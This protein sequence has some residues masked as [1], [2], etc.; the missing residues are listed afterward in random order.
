MISTHNFFQ[1]LQ[2][3]FPIGR[4]L[5]FSTGYAGLVVGTNFV[6]NIWHLELWQTLVNFLSIAGI[7]ICFL[8]RQR[9]ID[10]LRDF[11]HDAQYFPNRPLHRGLIT[12]QQLIALGIS[13]L[14]IEL[15][16]VLVI[17]SIL[18]YLIVLTFTFLMAKDF[19]IKQWLEKHFT[20]HFLIHEVFFIIFGWFFIS[21]LSSDDIT[22]T[23]Q[24]FIYTALLTG[25]I[26]IELIRKFKPRLDPKGVA[27]KDSYCVMWGRTKT[28]ILLAC[29]MML[30][31]IS[32]SMIKS[33][34]LF[35]LVGVLLS[36]VLW[37]ARK[38]DKRVVLVGIVQYMLFAILANIIW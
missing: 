38:R 18:Q 5:L 24:L 22:Q 14:I 35:I 28:I 7:F 12:K 17:G 31:S 4:V 9:A 19:F 25:P 27:V 15:F 37:K 1:Y 20:T 30:T 13:A 3:R 26:S 21:S 10:E 16:L 33:N 8:F 6:T 11:K 29:L 23:S 32:L 34:S 2:E 36:V